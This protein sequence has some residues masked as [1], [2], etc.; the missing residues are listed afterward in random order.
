VRK[1]EKEAR[2]KA[3]QCVSVSL[4]FGRQRQEDYYNFEVP[5]ASM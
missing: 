2:I 1:K 4:V 5:V 3:R